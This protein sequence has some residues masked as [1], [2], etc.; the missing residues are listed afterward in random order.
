M[1]SRIHAVEIA[2]FGQLLDGREAHI[3]TLRNQNGMRV[4]VSDY[5]AT[6]VSVFTPDR[7]AIVWFEIRP[8]QIALQLGE[9]GKQI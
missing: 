6:L 5:G 7:D 3:Y 4:L 9:I 1:K 2:A 8:Q